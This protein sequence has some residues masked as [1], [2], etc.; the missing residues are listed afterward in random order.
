MFRGAFDCGFFV[1][2][3]GHCEIGIADAIAQGDHFIQ[4]VFQRRISPNP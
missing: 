1:Q 4:S 2:H 3:A